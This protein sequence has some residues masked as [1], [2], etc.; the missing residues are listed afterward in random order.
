[1]A[2]LLRP[3]E[4]HAGIVMGL[5]DALYGMGR[6]S[7]AKDTLRIAGLARKT[8]QEAMPGSYQR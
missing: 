6:M 5:A 2:K 8:M 3:D 7:E 1:M 4:Q